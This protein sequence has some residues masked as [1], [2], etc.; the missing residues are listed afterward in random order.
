MSIMVFFGTDMQI[1]RQRDVLLSKCVRLGECKFGTVKDP[2]PLPNGERFTAVGANE[3][4]PIGEGQR[5]RDKDRE[6][7]R[8]SIKSLDS[9]VHEGG[10]SRQ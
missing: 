2:L 1:L 4:S 5:D 7:A 8:Q 9:H 6:D 10:K 3:I